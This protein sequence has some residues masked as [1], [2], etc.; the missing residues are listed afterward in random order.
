M[1]AKTEISWTDATWSPLRVRVRDDASAI[2]TAKGYAS[3]TQIAE[4]MRGRVGPHCEHVSH[5]CDNCYSGTNNG[6]CLPTN[7]TGLPFDRRS[8]DLIEAFVDEKILL[9]PLKWR[10]PKKIFVENQS[11]LFGEWNTDE[12]IDHVF[13]VMALCPQHT[14]QV[15]TKRPERMLK[16]LSNAVGIRERL[17]EL[18]LDSRF[19]ADGVWGDTRRMVLGNPSRAVTADGLRGGWRSP[20][21][22]HVWLGVSCEDQKTADARIP[23]LL[24][25]PAA[26][27]FVSYEPA[28]GP[29]DFFS[30]PQCMDDNEPTREQVDGPLGIRYIRHGAPGLDWII[31]G[32][33]SGPGARPC[34]IEWARQTVEQCKESG[35]ACFVKQ[36]GANPFCNIEAHTISINLKDPKG[37]NW[38]EWPEDLRVREFPNG[39]IK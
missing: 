34:D 17:S 14:F 1:G 18:L 5:G 39:G 35:T 25:T 16:Y 30:V 26:I 22:S 21:P 7:G 29:V 28:L 38:S 37:G 15:L 19:L 2:A 10:T 4:K 32:G 12:M 20:L 9:Q 27:R 23:L 3:L 13:A 33:E 11:D 8:R 36:L 6:R 24:Q 31:V